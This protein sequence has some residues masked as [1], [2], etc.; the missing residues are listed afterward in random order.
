M[1]LGERLSMVT[2]VL[3]IAFVVGGIIFALIRSTLLAFIRLNDWPPLPTYQVVAVIA[4][5]VLVVYGFA[6]DATFGFMLLVPVVVLAIFPELFMANWKAEP[7]VDLPQQ[8]RLNRPL[9]LVGG[10]L[11][12]RI[13][14]NGEDWA[15]E[16]SGDDHEPPETGEMVQIVGRDGLKLLIVRCF[17]AQRP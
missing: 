8:V 1:T 16:L 12:T 4:Y 13:T 3:L 17:N 7:S 11:K 14:I 9:T 15:A 10:K 2:V 5:P 6:I